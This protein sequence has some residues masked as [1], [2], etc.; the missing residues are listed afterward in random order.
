M[1]ENISVAGT[2]NAVPSITDT[3]QARDYA[4]VCSACGSESADDGLRLECAQSHAP[5]LLRT[6]YAA[7][8]FCPRADD[9]GLFRYRDWLPV[10][11]AIPNVSRTA[12]YR[13]VKL[14]GLLGLANLW[15]AFNGY[16]PERGAFFETATFKELEAYTVLA[17]LPRRRLVLTVPSSGNT[18]AAFAWAC[19][20]QR[21]P[22]L[23]IVPSA[24]MARFRFRETLDPCVSIVAIEDGDY[25]DAIGFA[26]TLSRSSPFQLE[27]GAKNV[28]R[29]DGL[30]TVMLSAFE[31][32][33]RLPA[34]YFQAAGSGTGAIAVHEAAK[35]LLTPAGSTALPRIMLCQNKPFTPIY[36]SWRLGRRT[37]AGGS[38][39][40][41]RRAIRQVVARE[42]TNWAPPYGVPGG[43]YDV[44][45]ESR[46]D[47]LVT[48]NSSV[49]AAMAAFGELEG[50]DIEPAAGV[51]VACLRQAVEEQRIDPQAVVLLNVTGGGRIRHGTEHADVQ[52]AS[53]LRVTREALRFRETSEQ[54]SAL[55]LQNAAA[56]DLPS[57]LL[58]S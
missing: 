50:I 40:H 39:E 6:R 21:V 44:L 8:A 57:E 46:G 41:F 23:I 29:R 11:R 7:G 53:R 18:G 24:A 38:A 25:P 19:S 13:S 52:A 16:W 17:R 34:Y 22:C 32:M 12:V 5:A 10:V 33:Q 14:A 9:D 51:A 49:R 55:C 3:A 43:L 48:D 45:T 36:D 35:R 26:E 2:G 54:V 1:A 37:A 15:I 27:G 47:V 42:L 30:A 56:G 4:L 28:G 31:K 20:G 58:P